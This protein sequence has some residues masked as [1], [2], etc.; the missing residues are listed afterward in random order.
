MKKHFLFILLSLMVLVVANAKEVTTQQAKQYATSFMQVRGLSSVNIQSVVAAGK[1]GKAFYI[2]NLAP[3]GWVIIS[4]DDVVTPVLAYSKSGSL[5]YNLLPENM[6]YLLYEYE[7]QILKIAKFVTSPH[8]G[9]KNIAGISTRASGQEIAPLI[10][11]NW[12][13]SAPFNAYCPQKKALVGCVA[14]AMSQ[15]MSVQHW[16]ARPK[17][18]ISYTSPNYGGLSINFDSE[19]AYNWERIIGG[20]DN[21]D[22][23]ARLLYHA[24]MSV[25]MD[26]G[27]DGSGIPSSEV[28]RIS[29]AL[30]D[31]FSYPE[32]VK[33]YW[34]DEYDGDWEQLLL[35]EL[36]AG[37][38]IVYNAVDTKHSAGHSFN[39]DGYDGNGHFHI[40]WG[41]SGYGNGEFSIDNLRDATMEMD[42]DAYHAAV[43]G[44]GA[45]DQILKSISL[46]N[47]KIEEKLP[48][49]AVVG[50]IK[51]NNEEVKSAYEVT[52]HGT[53]DVK[54][55]GYK[56]VPFKYEN[57]ML[58]TTEPLD[59][60]ISQWNIEI[61]VQ[62]TKSDA[63]LTQGFR[64]IVEPWKSIEETTMLKFD[65]RTRVFTLTTKHNVTYTLIGADGSILKQGM[66]DPLPELTLSASVLSEG[67]N[68]LQL[69]CVDE[70]KNIR[71]ISNK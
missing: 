45:P 15:A 47:N 37:R 57:G 19:L 44:I 50:A 43:I 56:Q 60:S 7:Q 62:D 65:R 30:K 24:G 13:Q 58:K 18:N 17:G 51:V 59:S 34:R 35:N 20:N 39:I 16:P 8:R 32:S 12:N 70:V 49:G 46:S 36:N 14:V 68:I 42:Y 25:R 71:I 38:A 1:T 41:W 26:Y 33:Y 54:S 10:K 69:K 27:E 4:A 21:Y 40:N 61:T 29:D 31:N 64:I 23:V 3:K 2:I 48:A 66:L 53:Y 22:E 28:Y 63:E 67:E 11:V 9:W 5:D 6:N 52:V 55:G